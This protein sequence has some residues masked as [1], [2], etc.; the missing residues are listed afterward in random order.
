[1]RADVEKLE[2]MA[3]RLGWPEGEEGASVSGLI[4]RVCSDWLERA[5]GIPL[6]SPEI[7]LPSLAEVVARLAR[8]ER[9]LDLNGPVRPLEI[10]SE[11][12]SALPETGKTH[13]PTRA[14]PRGKYS[15]SPGESQGGNETPS[16]SE[17]EGLAAAMKAKGYTALS[18]SEALGMKDRGRQ[19]GRWLKGK[20]AVPEKRL[21]KLRELLG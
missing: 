4:R 1:M 6:D 15:K 21:S 18:L 13:K 7:H 3:R 8:V 9:R 12:P 16:L 17:S 19:V 5:G 10:T 14:S 2:E 11:P 20:S